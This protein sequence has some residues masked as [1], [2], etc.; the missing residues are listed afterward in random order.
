MD[1]ALFTVGQHLF[2]NRNAYY[3]GFKT[4]REIY[5]ERKSMPKRRRTEAKRTYAFV[6]NTRRRGGRYVTSM[7][8]ANA[9]GKKRRLNRRSRKRTRRNTKGLKR[10]R[11]AI[12]NLQRRTKASTSVQTVRSSVYGGV[13]VD[14]GKSKFASLGAFS[15]TTIDNQLSTVRVYDEDT[16]NVQ[17][18]DLR[19]T[20][21]NKVLFKQVGSTCTIQNNYAAPVHVRLYC[22]TP[23][24]DTNQ[25]PE[26]SFTDGLADIGGAA[27]GCNSDSI[28]VYPTDCATFNK[29]WKIEDSVTR[30][31]G[32]GQLI[33]RSYIKKNI[34]YSTA[35]T[36]HHGFT[37]QKSLGGHVWA[38]RLEGSLCHD[39]VLGISNVSTGKAGIDVCIKFKSKFEYNSAG[40]AYTTLLASPAPEAITNAP[41]TGV[42][43]ESQQSTFSTGTTA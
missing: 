23:K 9:Y 26:D 6:P 1:R 11:K 3:H 5:N 19:I 16:G 7:W 35:E 22:L 41:V 25:S 39:S 10:V 27:Y 28:L 32:P 24:E 33:T 38:V 8:T 21:Q 15:T 36:D 14:I 34:M 2:N 30:Y 37:Y 42:P 12:R 40:M 4:L 17:S 18:S 43:I 13:E 20:E 29:L 31:L